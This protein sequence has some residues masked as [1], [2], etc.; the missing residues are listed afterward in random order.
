MKRPLAVVATLVL[1]SGVAGWVVAQKVRGPV[2]DGY[3]VAARPL[4]RARKR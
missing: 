1:A 3:R 2:F 4:A